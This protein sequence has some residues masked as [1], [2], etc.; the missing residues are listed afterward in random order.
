MQSEVA[1]LVEGMTHPG[2]FKS[3]VIQWG[4]PIPSFGNLSTAKLATIGLNPSN[5]EFVDEQGKELDG[6]NRRFHTLKSLGIKKWG[7]AKE[8]HF[9]SIA[10]YCV[11]YFNRNPYD[12]W[13]KR[14]DHIISGT[15]RSFYFPSGTACHLD[16]I[17]YATH[18]KWA[19]LSPI[20]KSNL[21][22]QSSNSLGMLLNNSEIQVIVLNGQTVVN[23]LE[24][25]A[26]VYLTKE[27]RQEW[28]LPRNS[29][30]G[31]VGYSYQG[32]IDNIGEVKLKKTIKVLG[33]NHNIQ[34]SFGVTKAV[35]TS[36]R[37]WI[38]DN[39]MKE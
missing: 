9:K 11:D 29:G 19:E 10:G 25:I 22:I 39:L 18:S 38:T 5:R 2:I 35:Q 23:N 6:D 32:Y 33:Y 4:A 28:T 12:S 16:L 3:D 30:H 34:S 13:F 21:L 17:P 37:N 7:E 31:V 14:L 15:S 27:C 20:K 36:I 24:R 8:S 1:K 26:N